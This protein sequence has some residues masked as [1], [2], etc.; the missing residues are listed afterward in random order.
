MSI[1]SIIS[2]FIFKDLLSGAGNNYLSSA[3]LTN[4]SINSVYQANLEYF[5][6]YSKKIPIFFI[7]LGFLSFYFTLY[8]WQLFLNFFLLFKTYFYLNTFYIKIIL[9]C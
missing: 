2:G 9:V 3:I 7:F 6:F 4:F 5:V 8:F 1:L